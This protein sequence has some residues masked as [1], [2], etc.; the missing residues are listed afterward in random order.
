M[1]ACLWA[2]APISLCLR[3]CIC[4]MGQQQSRL[5]GL[6]GGVI[7]L[8]Y[9]ECLEQSLALIRSSMRLLLLLFLPL[10]VLPVGAMDGIGEHRGV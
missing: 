9:K 7:K 5:Q 2:G 4:E 1:A 8:I 6:L 3:L 10:L